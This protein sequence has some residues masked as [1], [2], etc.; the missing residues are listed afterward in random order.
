MTDHTIILL[1]K[2]WSLRYDR[3]Q[4]KICKS[5][6]RKDGAYWHAVSFIA[7]EKW[8]LERNL[9]DLGIQIDLEAQAYIDAMPDTFTKWFQTSDAEIRRIADLDKEED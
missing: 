2:K 7:T 3:L 5:K 9:R 1:N 6:K 8:I 4:W